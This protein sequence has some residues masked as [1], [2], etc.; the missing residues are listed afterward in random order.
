MSQYLVEN[1]ST[2]LSKIIFSARAG[3]ID[4]KALNEWKYNDINCVM[5]EMSVEN[6]D[7]FMSCK[8]YGNDHLKVH[9]NKIFE[10]EPEEQNEIAIE[11]KRRQYM[12]KCKQ[13]EAGL[14]LH[15]APLLQ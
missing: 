9:W 15:L 11:I 6:F 5:C 2:T 7:H 14:P 8:A 4:L 10:N 12:R 13:D 3:I 1:K